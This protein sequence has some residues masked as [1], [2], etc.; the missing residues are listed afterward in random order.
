MKVNIYW[1]FTLCQVLPWI[2]TWHKLNSVIRILWKILI[3]PNLQVDKPK[4]EEGKSCAWEGIADELAGLGLEPRDLGCSLSTWRSVDSSMGFCYSVLHLPLGSNSL[5]PIR[6]FKFLTGELPE[7]GHLELEHVP[8]AAMTPIPSTNL[9]VP[10]LRI[11]PSGFQYTPARQL[12]SLSWTRT[13]QAK[14]QSTRKK[15]LF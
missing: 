12:S 7:V 1:M 3:I 9:A 14:A 13:R 5:S 4:H 10:L 11:Y 2:S 6:N 8:L 15:D